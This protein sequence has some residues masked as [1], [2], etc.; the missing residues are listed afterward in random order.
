V[1]S[2]LFELGMEPEDVQHL[3]RLD[4]GRVLRHAGVS[5]L[6]YTRR[7]DVV[8]YMQAWASLMECSLPRLPDVALAA[9]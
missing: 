2:S 5:S 4:D 7:E 9:E 1:L 6:S 8:R 3:E